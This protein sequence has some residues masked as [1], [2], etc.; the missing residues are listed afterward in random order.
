MGSEMCIRDRGV[1]SKE[2]RE[3][4]ILQRVAGGKVYSKEWQTGV[5]SKEWQRRVYSKER[6][7]GGGG[8]ILQR[9]ADGSLLQRVADG[10]LLQR[11]ARGVGWWGRAGLMRETKT[12][13]EDESYRTMCSSFLTP[14]QTLEL[15]RLGGRVA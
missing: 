6:R 9:V 14:Y 5:Y 1:Y 12:N 7:G 4:S 8:Y 10:G 2:W 3:G 13:K 11:V 15:K